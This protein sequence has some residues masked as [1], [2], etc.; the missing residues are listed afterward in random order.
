MEADVTKP[1]VR[2]KVHN[3]DLLT[4]RE[5]DDLLLE[6]N[7]LREELLRVRED[8]KRVRREECNRCVSFISRAADDARASNRKKAAAELDML[9][10]DIAD[11]RE[12]E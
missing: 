7:A 10:R 4:A 1:A 9:A 3:G 8:V 11:A 2:M 5:G 6:V 12:T